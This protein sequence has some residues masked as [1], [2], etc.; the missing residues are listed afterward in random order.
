MLLIVFVGS[1][2]K[3]FGDS[4]EDSDN[5]PTGE[6]FPSDDDMT[7]MDTEMLNAV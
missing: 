5:E 7:E 3:T 6:E 4:D 1:S 2:A